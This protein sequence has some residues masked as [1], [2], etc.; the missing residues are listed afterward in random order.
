MPLSFQTENS[1]N[2]AFGFFNIE[3]DLLLLENYFFFADRFCDWMTKL[4][5]SSDA[6]EH[7]D[8]EYNIKVIQSVEDIGDLIGAIHGIRFTGFIGELYKKFPFPAD[9]HAFK[10]NPLGNKTRQ[11][12][13]S[14]IEK[15][16]GDGIL[17]IRFK[18][19]GM[20]NIGPYRFDKKVFHK[21]LRYVVQGGCPRWKNE[22]PPEYV[23]K[24]E[25]KIK[26]SKHPFFEGVF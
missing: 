25:S 11:F 7:K 15:Y 13:T 20:V 22:A 18:P 16:A 23:V 14:L 17:A 19:D 10:Q 8:F 4:A 24:M 9:S 2:I 6:I 5:E 1:G 26:M 21:L 3:S 12:V